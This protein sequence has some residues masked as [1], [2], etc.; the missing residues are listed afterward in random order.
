MAYPGR[1]ESG[2]GRLFVLGFVFMVLGFI[3]LFASALLM[4]L[5]GAGSE[6]EGGIGVGGCVIV[7]FVPICFGAGTPGLST[8]V[9]ILALILSILSIVFLLILRGVLR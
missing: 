7:F 6:G 5:Q 2:F 8:I 9:L 4:V 3:V 1:V